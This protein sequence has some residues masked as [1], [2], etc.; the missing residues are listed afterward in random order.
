MA[1]Q[2]FADPWWRKFDTPTD[3]FRD[4]SGFVNRLPL[5]LES[6]EMI[7][8]GTV[9]AGKMWAE[10][11]NEEF[12]PILV[13]G[14][15][16]VSI[17]LN[18]FSDTDCGG[19]YLETWYNTFVTRRDA[20]QL[21]L[22]MESPLSVVIDHPQCQNF[23][24]RV[25]CSDAPGNPGAAM[26]AIV[27]GRSVFGFPKHPELGLINFAYGE[28]DGQKVTWEFDASHHGQR[29]ISAR[30]AL[31]ETDPN[32]IPVPLDVASADDLVIG[33]PHLGGTH[34]GDN[35]AHQVFFGQTLAGTQNTA[36]WNPETDSIVIGDDPHYGA[37]LSRWGFEPLVKGHIPDFKIAARKPV[38]WISGAEAAAAV[39]EHEKMMAAGLKAGAIN[40][41][42]SKL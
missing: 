1:K 38:G 10:F 31:P 42:W 24:Q 16:V 9:D 19:S 12:Q 8:F 23:L 37:P 21:S 2:R 41:P 26:K 40:T 15:A 17:W 20:P 13:G 34:R 5:R 18:N 28:K 3:G 4:A 14:K 30:I 7:V 35:G 36:V 27:G 32:H 11:A 6:T 22:P 39:K 33:S 29:C 25:V